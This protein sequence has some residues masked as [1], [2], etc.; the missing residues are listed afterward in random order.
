MPLKHIP[1]LPLCLVLEVVLV[2]PLLR[3]FFYLMDQRSPAAGACLSPAN[4]IKNQRLAILFLS[5][6]IFDHR[7][8]IYF[9]FVSKRIDHNETLALAFMHRALRCMCTGWLMMA[10]LSE[11]KEWGVAVSID[12]HVGLLQSKVRRTSVIGCG[13]CLI[14]QVGRNQE[15]V[16]VD[17]LSRS[18]PSIW[19]DD[20][21]RRR[22]AERLALGLQARLTFEG[23]REKRR[24]KRAE[25]EAELAAAADM[26]NSETKNAEGGSTNLKAQWTSK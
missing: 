11:S 6:L 19:R 7:S 23:R 24:S 14:L 12:I 9:Y 18:S 2:L 4:S 15:R 3:L 20:V 17:E 5:F 8:S 1:P 25:E 26:Q 21:Q 16:M 13:G 10:S 22:T